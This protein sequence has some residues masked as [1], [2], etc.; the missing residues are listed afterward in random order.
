MDSNEGHDFKQFSQQGIAAKISN[1]KAVYAMYLNKIDKDKDLKE[2]LVKLYQA[3]QLQE[4]SR[5]MLLAE[6]E[7]KN[8]L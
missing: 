6:S 4:Q 8:E 5:L 7:M 3:N 1:A 2:Q